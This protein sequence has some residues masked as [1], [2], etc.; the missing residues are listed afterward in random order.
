MLNFRVSGLFMSRINSQQLQ[1]LL[2]N[3][4]RTKGYKLGDRID[5]SA[6][7]DVYWISGQ[8]I[9]PGSTVLKVIDIK[10]NYQRL[11]PWDGFNTSNYKCFFQKSE[12][13]FDE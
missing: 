11:Y 3:D 1:H 5:Y 4:I 6:F 12:R 10:E 2:D 7:A 9:K 8:Q 13:P